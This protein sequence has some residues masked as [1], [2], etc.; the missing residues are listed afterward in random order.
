V[1]PRPASATSSSPPATSSPPIGTSTPTVSHRC[2][3]LAN[4]GAEVADRE[5]FDDHHEKLR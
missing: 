4:G 3:P 2:G 1:A 5:N